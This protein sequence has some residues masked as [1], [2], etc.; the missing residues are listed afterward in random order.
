MANE[1]VLAERVEL[2]DP[3]YCRKTDARPVLHYARQSKATT[4]SA[5]AS[6]F[7]D[8][9]VEGITAISRYVHPDTVIVTVSHR[10]YKIAWRPNDPERLSVEWLPQHDISGRFH[11]GAPDPDQ[12]TD[13]P[14]AR[15]LAAVV[16]GWPGPAFVR[17]GLTDWQ[18]APEL[19]EAVTRAIDGHFAG[20]EEELVASVR[21]LGVRREAIGDVAPF[22][23]TV[24]GKSKKNQGC[25]SST[26]NAILEGELLLGAAQGQFVSLR[27]RGTV[28]SGA[29]KCTGGTDESDAGQSSSPCPADVT[30]E[31]GWQCA[32]TVYL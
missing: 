31:L 12:G 32:G 27:L 7:S 2:A 17:H 4:V 28:G 24:T 3:S 9:D 25:A 20:L 15:A 23:V 21:P 22:H 10:P 14:L 29:E 5:C 18:E 6:A 1:A 16:L 26:S 11:G 19:G 30:W 13:P 8:A